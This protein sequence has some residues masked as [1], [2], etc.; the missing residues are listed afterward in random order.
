MAMRH[1][2][3]AVSRTFA[4]ALA[5]AFLAA[6]A[7]T[8]AGA[9]EGADAHHFTFGVDFGLV[10]PSTALDS[11][12]DG[13][14]GKLR[15]SEDDRGAVASRGYG[16][17][18]GRLNQAWTAH[19]VA[20]IVDDASDGFDLTEAYF[21]WQP[22]PRS[23][24]RQHWKLGLFHAP[25]SFENTGP[26]W[27][28]PFTLSASAVNTWIGEE[29]R[30]FGAEW[31]LQR[32]IGEP[33]S[34]HEISAHAG[35][36]FGN[37]PAGSLL[38]WKGWSLHDRQSRVNDELPLAPLPQLQPGTMFALQA[39]YVEPWREVDGRAGYYVGADW[40][41]RRRLDLAL[42]HYDNRANPTEIEDGQYAWHTRF[43]QLAVQIELPAGLGLLAQWMTGS[44]VMGPVLVTAHAVDTDFRARYVLLT[45]AVNKHRLSV[46]YD[47]FRVV[48]LDL[49]PNDDNSDSGHAWTVAY[50]YRGSDRW[51]LGAEWLEIRSWHPA[52]QYFGQAPSATEQL[53]QVQASLRF[54]ARP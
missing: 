18:S 33:G 4:G 30:P 32:R 27:S 22:I 21:E 13:G 51:S 38:A 46:R 53:V 16:I 49:V 17:Y 25:W 10:R 2:L 3:L 14:I 28:T 44:T 23:A 52:W 37:D 54:G 12:T 9:G 39:P 43:E 40:R 19:A 50:R 1:P 29:L 15:Y 34:P 48:D 8:P 36:F 42:E 41:Y 35:A 6:L 26:G 11:W 20:D 7:P 47:D 5:A 31:T 45:K 24:N